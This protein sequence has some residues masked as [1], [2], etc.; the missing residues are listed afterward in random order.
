MCSADGCLGDCAHQVSTRPSSGLGHRSAIQVGQY[1]RH[2][3]P[4]IGFEN[5]VPHLVELDCGVRAGDVLAA[6]V[7]RGFGECRAGSTPSAR[8]RNKARNCSRT[9][10]RCSGSG[11]AAYEGISRRTWSV[12]SSLMLS[13]RDCSDSHSLRSESLSGRAT[14]AVTRGIVESTIG[15]LQASSPS[16]MIRWSSRQRRSM[17]TQRRAALPTVAT[18]AVSLRQRTRRP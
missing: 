2:H 11:S 4:G 1:V 3:G 7:R 12:I 18:P 8:P 10:R 13:N 15:L 5:P 6:A 14:G 9:V 17:L 16:V